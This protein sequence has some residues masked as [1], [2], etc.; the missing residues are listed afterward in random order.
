MYLSE[1]YIF[2]RGRGLGIHSAVSVQERGPEVQESLALLDLSWLHIKCRYRG[3]S[4]IRNRRPPQDHHRILGIVLLHGP[5][6]GVFLM[7]EVP[8]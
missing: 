5:G 6:R 1:I 8:L 7:S 2:V 3:T 4:L